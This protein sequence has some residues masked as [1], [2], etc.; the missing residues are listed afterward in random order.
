MLD[1]DKDRRISITDAL[2]HN[3]FKDEV[4]KTS[5]NASQLYVRHIKRLIICQKIKKVFRSQKL[6]S[7]VDYRERDLTDA[8]ISSHFFGLID[9]N[10]VFI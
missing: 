10:K 5:G 2:N 7:I 8:D 1:L 4:E 3:L 6:R 9:K